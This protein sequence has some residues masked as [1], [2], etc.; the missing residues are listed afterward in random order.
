MAYKI[1]KPNMQQN[2]GDF[3]ALGSTRWREK[4]QKR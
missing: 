3:G 2:L 4:D 1:Y